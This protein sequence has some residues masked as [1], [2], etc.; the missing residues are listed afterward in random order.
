MTQPHETSSL[1]PYVLVFAGLLVLLGATVAI[2]FVDL[3]HHVSIGV[4]LLIASLKGLLILGWFMHLKREP[5][6]VWMFAS[7]GF[8]W[9]VIMVLL[10]FSDYAT[11]RMPGVQIKG[12][13]RLFSR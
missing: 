5:W 8:V 7:A 4:A 10:T 6:R 3:G 1:R 9:L 13:P 12:E 2:A 11:R